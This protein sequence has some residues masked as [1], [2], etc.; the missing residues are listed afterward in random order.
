MLYKVEVGIVELY[1]GATVA[2]PS[3]S[4]KLTNAANALELSLISW[5]PSKVPVNHGR[6]LSFQVI[7]AVL[8]RLAR[9]ERNARQM[10]I[11]SAYR[12]MLTPLSKHF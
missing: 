4:C 10:H 1:L 7:A 6:L 2:A 12:V 8:M 11:S 9:R 3:Q 5:R